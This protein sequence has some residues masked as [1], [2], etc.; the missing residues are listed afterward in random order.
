MI[1][2]TFGRAAADAMPGMREEGFGPVAFTSPFDTKE[3]VVRRAKDH[4]YGLR[5]AVFGG[6]EAK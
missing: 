4:K 3:E 2:P 5:A 6:K 1:H